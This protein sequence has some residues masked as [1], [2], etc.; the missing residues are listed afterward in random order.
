MKYLVLLLFPIF[1]FAQDF[2]KEIITVDNPKDTVTLAGT[3]TLPI[4]IEN[5]PLAILISGSGQS[6][7]DETIFN[8]KPFKQIAEAFV[9]KGV[10]VFRYDDRGGN[11]STG[12]HT[13]NSTS[14]ELSEDAECVLKYFQ[15]DPRFESSKIGF[16][17]H[18]EGGFIAPMIA[19][20][21]TDV[22][23]IISMAG[24]A[25]NGKDLLMTQNRAI[26]KQ[27]GISEAARELY[28]NEVFEPTLNLLVTSENIDS[29]K[30]QVAALTEEYRQKAGTNSLVPAVFS[31][32]MFADRVIGQI[33][34]VW[35]TYFIKTD[36][37]QFWSKVTCPVLAL[38]GDKDVQ[39]DA[40]NNLSAIEKH[41][42]KAGNTNYEIKLIANH[43]H[44]FQETENGSIMEYGRLKDG[45]SS[46]TLDMMGDWIL[47][48]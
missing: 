44:L 18:S 46:L 45:V 14:Y 22:A 21:N 25:V 39:V 37:A 24:T 12:R 33:G 2:S 6:D 43:N 27:Q 29:T 3:L 17:G 19:A 41:L 26:F 34:G 4:N 13:G 38:N 23:F 31:S 5:P 42:T 8:H 10:A 28:L 48:L 9:A 30:N 32:E 35:G 40:D 20:R 16:I 15:K 36:P 7:R 1:G 11:E 47:D